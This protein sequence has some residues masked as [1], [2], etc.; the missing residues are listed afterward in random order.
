MGT[1]AGRGG[2]VYL[3]ATSAAL[4][5]K[6]GEARSWAISIDHA[7]DEDNA[8]G[9]DRK[10]FVGG[11]ISSS[12]NVEYNLDP[13]ASTPFDA[14]TAD[15]PVW[16]HLYPQESVPGQTYSGKLWAKMTAEGGLGGTARGTLTGDMDGQIRTLYNNPTTVAGCVLW[17]PA[18][19]ITGVLDGG[20]VTSWTDESGTGNTVVQADAA[21]QPTYLTGAING[22][23]AVLFDGVNDL[24][25]C[26]AS[27]SMPIQTSGGTVFIV[28]ALRT[29]AAVN[30]HTALTFGANSTGRYV[31]TY[32][33]N[34]GATQGLIYGQGGDGASPKV[35]STVPWVADTYQ[36]ISVR[37]PGN[38]AM[39]QRINN[40][41]EQTA[42]GA[43][44]LWTDVAIHVGHEGWNLAGVASK[45]AVAEIA[46]FGSKLSDANW[47][48]VAEGLMNQYGLT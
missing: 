20:V 9:D 26:A 27:S 13:A 34:G 21:R 19:Q 30:S 47:T 7:I 28:V 5:T 10:T 43:P 45:V 23:P 8:M 1:I 25:S 16:F 46:V 35:W 22:W 31:T 41:D 29:G 32:D 33:N 12:V 37:W 40:A 24:L 2:Q 6:L 39:V 4:A 42:A 48:A 15:G 18:H 38:A 14:A 36:L 44:G 11:I 3:A 17:L